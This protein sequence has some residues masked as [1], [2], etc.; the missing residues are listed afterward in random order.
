MIYQSVH[1]PFAN[2]A[3]MWKNDDEAEMAVNE[4]LNCVRDCA[5][6]NV[7]IMV[8][9]TYIGFETSTGPNEAGIEN[10]GRVIEEA[11]KNNVKIAFENTEG[12]EYLAALMK[13][14]SKY[15]NVGFF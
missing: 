9:H 12:E 8:A 6:S 11:A 2:A 3:K 15:E 13:A 4:L 1:A 5:E 10:F 7:P 14:F